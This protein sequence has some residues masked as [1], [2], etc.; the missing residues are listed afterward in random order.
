MQILSADACEYFA[1]RAINIHHSFLRGFKGARA[2][3]Q[4]FVRGVNKWHAER[5]VIRNGHETVVLR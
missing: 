1:D 4:A 5:R 2:Y 3:H